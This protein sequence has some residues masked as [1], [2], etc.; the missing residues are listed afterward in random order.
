MNT[1][2]ISPT[3]VRISLDETLTDSFQILDRRLQWRP[4]TNNLDCCEEAPY[5]YFRIAL[6]L[7]QDT[8]TF[9]GFAT[10]APF[11]L[12]RDADVQKRAFFLRHWVRPNAPHEN[13]DTALVVQPYMAV[14]ALADR[15]LIR[16]EIDRELNIK[17][18]FKS[19][20]FA[21]WMFQ[22]VQVD[23]I[24][25]EMP[26]VRLA[27]AIE[28]TVTPEERA[29][30]TGVQMTPANISYKQNDAVP[31][32]TSPSNPSMSVGMSAETTVHGSPPLIATQRSRSQAGGSMTR[33][34][35]LA[36]ARVMPPGT[37]HQGSSL[38]TAPTLSR[39]TVY[40]RTPSNDGNVPITRKVILPGRVASV[41]SVA[42]QKNGYG[43]STSRHVAVQMRQSV[44]VRPSPSAG[45]HS[46]RST[47]RGPSK[48]WGAAS[49]S[50]GSFGTTPGKNRGNG[51][52]VGSQFLMMSENARANTHPDVRLWEEHDAN[53][54][55]EPL[56]ISEDA[57]TPSAEQKGTSYGSFASKSGKTIILDQ[58]RQIVEFD[59]LDASAGV[60]A[61]EATGMALCDGTQSQLPHYRT[62]PLHLEEMV[63]CKA[64]EC[65][66]EMAVGRKETQRPYALAVQSASEY[67]GT[68]CDNRKDLQKWL[69]E[70]AER[71][72]QQSLDD[73]DE[74]GE[75][76]SD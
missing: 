24:I 71:Q 50:S 28:R 11:M 69:I 26:H 10:G 6:V 73:D 15:L 38:T 19:V 45:P 23:A 76:G 42:L 16:V 39:S 30:I 34:G 72:E 7:R 41:S 46:M 65:L 48:H 55:Y 61:V 66:N 70:D 49:F 60:D 29:L 2:I 74:E 3:L 52:E 18:T 64:K 62:D 36:T 68:L 56:F 58:G 27:F 35:G 9:A 21:T 63:V 75:S 20:P 8:T 31:Q 59:K 51:H 4:L 32:H 47:G 22:V 54:P 44:P 1:Y 14:G 25:E 40:Q 13:C 53:D 57:R 43:L 67:N 37:T 33:G 12:T 17:D 5:L